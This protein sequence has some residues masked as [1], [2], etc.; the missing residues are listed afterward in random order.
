MENAMS[1]PTAIGFLGL[2]QMGAPMAERLLAPD[3]RL[4]VFDPRPEAMAPFAERGAVACASPAAV[5]AEAEI[6]FAC[7]PNAHVSEAVAAEVVGGPALRL[8]AE[9][10]TIGREAVERIAALLAA[11]GIACVDAPISGGPAGA[12]AGTLAMLAAGAPQAVAALRPWQLRIGKTVFV[13]GERPGQAQVMKLVNNL[14]FAA[15]LVAACEGLAMGAKAGL[16]S[17]A[18]LAMVN[19]GTGRS[20]ATERVLEEVLSGRF[21]FGAALSVLDKDVRLG[22]AEAAALDVPMW[23][24]EQA[25]RVWRFAATQGAGAEDLTSIAR[26][27]EGWARAE[28]R[29]P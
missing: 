6:V 25:A 17:D 27:M 8:Y 22:L 23:T 3:V 5:A 26:F 12:R 16:D 10:S 18:M 2:G 29:R 7:L 24:L 13:M 9:M 15:N 21:A 28:I 19:A 14:L 4:H 1:N 11:R 20:M